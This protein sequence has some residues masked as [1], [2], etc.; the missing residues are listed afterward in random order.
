MLI[1]V[2]AQDFLA[3]LKCYS[4]QVRRDRRLVAEDVLTSTV[5]SPRLCGSRLTLD[6][7]IEA[8]RVRALGYRVRACSLGQA[9]T[10]I[11]AERVV[12]MNANDLQAVQDE[13]ERILAGEV[14]DEDVLIWPELAIFQH[15]AGMPARHGSAL[16]PFLALQE[17]FIANE[18]RARLTTQEIQHG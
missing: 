18:R 11:A 6:A 16:L 7:V 14:P 3:M 9:T 2:D 5:Q 10:A 15:S 4:A 8:G 1:A 13:M 12:G 17:L